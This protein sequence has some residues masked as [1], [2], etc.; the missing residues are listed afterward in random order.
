VELAAASPQFTSSKTNPAQQ[1][2]TEIGGV[3]QA[4]N[5]TTVRKACLLESRQ[6][7]RRLP[8][9]VMEKIEKGT[10]M[11]LGFPHLMSEK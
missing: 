3:I 1:D 9:S 5:I 7:L 4:E 2:Q 6:N 10:L 8:E 11:A